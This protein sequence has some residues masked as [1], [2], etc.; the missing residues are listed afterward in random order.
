[1]AT[2]RA[3]EKKEMVE[4]NTALESEVARLTGEVRVAA[5][6]ARAASGQVRHI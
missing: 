1:M 4:K 2:E 5:Q 3:A 6:N